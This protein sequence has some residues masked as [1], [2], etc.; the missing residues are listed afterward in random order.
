MQTQVIL[1]RWIFEEKDTET[2]T[3][4]SFCRLKSSY[5]MIL[6]IIWYDV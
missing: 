3:H 6:N 4:I 1:E 2:V 5:Q